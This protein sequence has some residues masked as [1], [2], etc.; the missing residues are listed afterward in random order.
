MGFNYSFN[1]RLSI[2]HKSKSAHMYHQYL[3]LPFNGECGLQ[4]DL[5]HFL[6]DAAVP[7]LFILKCSPW[8]A[9]GV[10]SL[11]HNLFPL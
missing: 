6:E 7:L 3:D 4:T 9:F 2:W 1:A 8:E 5:G 11:I 10:C